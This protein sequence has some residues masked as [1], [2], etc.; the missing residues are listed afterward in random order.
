MYFTTADA[1]PADLMH[2]NADNRGKTPQR[3]ATIRDPFL[4]QFRS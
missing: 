1:V 3:P 2:G 4:T